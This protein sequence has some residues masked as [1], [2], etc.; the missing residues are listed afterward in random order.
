[1]GGFFAAT[2]RSKRIKFKI[3]KDV[4]EKSKEDEIE[5]DSGE[6]VAISDGGMSFGADNQYLPS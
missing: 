2:S 3:E 6:I 1:M 4:S 5:E